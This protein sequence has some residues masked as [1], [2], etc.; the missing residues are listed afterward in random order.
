MI[1]RR[2]FYS[3]RQ[4]LSRLCFLFSSNRTTERRSKGV[5]IFIFKINI[6]HAKKK[7]RGREKIWLFPIKTSEINTAEVEELF[8]V[9]DDA[10]ITKNV[11][12]V[13]LNK[14]MVEIKKNYGMEWG[15]GAAIH[16]SSG[17]LSTFDV[18]MDFIMLRIIWCGSLP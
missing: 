4:P 3:C 12:T 2:E 15:S 1:F 10:G 11:Y 17:D 13:P 18:R 16:R 5:S 8:K 6:Y 14:F 9:M 7:N